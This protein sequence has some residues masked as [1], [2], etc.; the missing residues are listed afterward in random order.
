MKTFLIDGYK[1]EDGY[2]S[3]AKCVVV[4]DTEEDALA[5]F[6]AYHRSLVGG[7]RIVTEIDLTKPGVNIIHITYEKVG[8]K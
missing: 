1:V 8:K 2:M 5:Q 3:E 4:S 7:P 6:Y